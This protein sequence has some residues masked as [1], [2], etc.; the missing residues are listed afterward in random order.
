MALDSDL[1]LTT[2]L[3]RYKLDSWFKFGDFASSTQPADTDVQ[4]VCTEYIVLQCN[5]YVLNTLY[6]RYVLNTLYYRYVLNT[7]YRYVLNILYFLS[8]VHVGYVV[9]FDMTYNH[10]QAKYLLSF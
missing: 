5:R 3:Q 4:Q 2:L 9:T 1:L 6:Y 7:L 10:D 8:A